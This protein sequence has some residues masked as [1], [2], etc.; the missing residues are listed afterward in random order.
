MSGKKGAFNPCEL[1][2]DPSRSSPLSFWPQYLASSC[3]SAPTPKL[4]PTD[5]HPTLT[6]LTT[7][8]PSPSFQSTVAPPLRVK[9]PSMLTISSI[10]S[11]TSPQPKSSK[12]SSPR[13][14]ARCKIPLGFVPCP[15]CTPPPAWFQLPPKVSTTRAAFPPSLSRILRASTTSPPPPSNS[16]C[17]IP[18]SSKPFH[19]L[20]Q[21]PLRP[22]KL[23]PLRAS[24]THSSS[25]RGLLA[26]PSPPKSLTVTA[27]RPP[28]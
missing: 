7:M 24:Y 9:P 14:T 23:P 6:A 5:N 1:A 20:K 18:I 26:S 28:R 22:Q 3:R 19:P 4:H 12:P 17:P 16:I 13:S 11:P 2:G 15:A 8:R 10:T 25:T 27:T 21:T